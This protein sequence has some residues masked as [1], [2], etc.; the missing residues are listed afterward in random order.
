MFSMIAIVVIVALV[1]AG[2]YFWARR[3]GLL[4]A[5]Q[6]TGQGH[7]AR[8]ISPLTEAAGYVGGILILAGGIAAVSQRWDQMTAWEHVGVFAGTAA[9]FLL[10]GILT[11]QIKEPAVQR[12]TDVMWFVSVAGVSGAIGFAS[13]EVYGNADEPTVLAVGA[14][15]TVFSAVL[16]LV[17]RHALEN[18][19]LFTG[20]VLVIVGIILAID[21]SAPSLAF[22]LALWVFGL[23][24]AW[25][26]W[27]GYAAPPW[28]A[29][30]SG[31]L[32]TV[33]VL[34]TAV[35]EFGWLYA[36]AIATA[37]AAMAA[38]VPLKNTPLLAV[39][40][41]AMFGYVTSAVVRYFHQ[42]VGVPGA[43]AI[44]GV[45]I[46]GLAIVSARLLRQTRPAKS[47]QPDAEKPSPEAH[48]P[49]R[50]EPVADESS[51]LALPKAS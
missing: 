9:L 42:S 36:V 29:I 16:W 22:A 1:F 45:L 20:L 51:D 15:V 21:A 28:V 49:A 2:F 7:G 32:L 50:G 17:R 4:T 34:S 41:L 48:P 33:I 37:A 26:G 38:S 13:N 24:W 30:S 6:A 12:L 23:A 35:S 5:G 10:A 19:A 8:R 44:T 27:R 14:G 18:F 43:L 31:V 3:Q 11:R 40:T 47:G 39:G 46:L 25:L